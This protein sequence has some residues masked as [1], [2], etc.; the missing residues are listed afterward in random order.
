MFTGNLVNR[1]LT[2]KNYKINMKCLTFKKPC[3]YGI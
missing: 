2:D 1:M 3:I